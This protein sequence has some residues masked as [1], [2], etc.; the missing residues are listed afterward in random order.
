VTYPRR[1]KAVNVPP[2]NLD[3][4][5]VLHSQPQGRVG[6]YTTIGATTGSTSVDSHTYGCRQRLLVLRS[7]KDCGTRSFG[8]EHQQYDGVL[9]CSELPCAQFFED[10]CAQEKMRER[11]RWRM[12]EREALLLDC[13]GPLPHLCHLLI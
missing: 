4:V 8:S 3:D 9:R 10:L 13:L 6:P 11:R 7:S 5:I 1:P 12:G 2:W